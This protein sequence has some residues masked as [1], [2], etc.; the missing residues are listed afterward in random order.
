MAT[1]AATNTVT[2]AEKTIT[3]T[4]S[5]SSRSRIIPQGIETKIDS[6]TAGA[7]PYFNSIFKQIAL[8]NLQNADILCEFIT[9]EYNERNVKFSTRLIHIKIISSF[10]KHLNYKDFLQVTKHDIMQYLSTLRKT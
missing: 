4:K 2:A 3:T 10:D 9:A 6:L 8:V 7:L 1:T 5:K